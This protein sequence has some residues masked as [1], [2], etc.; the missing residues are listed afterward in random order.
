MSP[1]SFS[2]SDCGFPRLSHAVALAVVKDLGFDAV[3]I[4]VFEGFDHTPP[5]DVIDNPSAAA[6]CVRQRLDTAGLAPADVFAI[7]ADSAEALAVNHPERDM[8]EE[9]LR[10]FGQIV[11]FATRLGA[12]GITVLPG[13]PFPELDD[14]AALELAADELQRRAEI[15]GEAGVALS[16]EPHFGSITP[17]P[18]RAV[19]LLGR[20]PDVGVTLDLSHFVYQ[21][22]PQE[23]ANGLIERSRHVHL[24]PAAPG[25]M[26][27]RP[28]EGTLD[29]EALL[30]RL[31]E[32]NYRG[33]LAFELIWQQWMEC[34]ELDCV[35]ETATLREHIAEAL[36]A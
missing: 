7:L 16:F 32:A 14:D 27:E 31:A 2:C 12:P 28:G 13:M 36:P 1:D 21:D 24:R 15:A 19:E 5:A 6:A 3:D 18:G 26:Q 29:F 11:A 4:C 9:S 25:R 10:Q 35:S 33:Y 30:A 23:E 34:N 22:I 8:R 17:T 20:A